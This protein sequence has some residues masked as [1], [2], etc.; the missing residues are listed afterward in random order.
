MAFGG[1]SEPTTGNLRCTTRPISISSVV[2]LRRNRRFCRGSVRM[3]RNDQPIAERRCPDSAGC[4]RDRLFN[5]D[6]GLRECDRALPLRTDILAA[7]QLFARNRLLV[8]L[9]NRQLHPLR[10]SLGARRLSVIR[11]H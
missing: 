10:D 4:I 5:W 3:D 6:C 11:G 9:T 7:A 8:R 1:G 2:G